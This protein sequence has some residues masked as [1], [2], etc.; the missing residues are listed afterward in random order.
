MRHTVSNPI[1]SGMHTSGAIKVVPSVPCTNSSTI[2]FPPSV[3]GHFASRGK[4]FLREGVWL[5]GAEEGIL[6]ETKTLHTR[7]K[8]QEKKGEKGKKE[9]FS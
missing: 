2:S 1:T 3:R 6:L 7:T 8:Q 5:R 9:K 4:C